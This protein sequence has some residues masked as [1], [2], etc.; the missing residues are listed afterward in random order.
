MNESPISPIETGTDV[1]AAC[2]R[3]LDLREQ[4]AATS[5]APPETERVPTEIDHEIPHRSRVCVYHDNCHDGITAAWV[6][7]HR[8]GADV[9]L[10]PAKYEVPPDLD[11]L[12]GRDVIIVDFSWKRPVLEQVLAVA[13]SLQIIDHHASAQSDLD[14]FPGCTFDM[15]RSGAGL[16]WDTLFPGEL[17]PVLVDLVEDRDLWRFRLKNTKAVHAACNLR[18]LDIENRRLLVEMADAEEGLEALVDVGASVLVYHD[19]LV[20]SGSRYRPRRVIGGHSVPC[21]PGGTV[22]LISD[23]G[24]ALCEGESFAATWAIKSDLT[25]LV[26]LRSSQ[27]GIDVCEIARAYGGGGHKHAAGFH[28][29]SASWFGGQWEKAPSPCWT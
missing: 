25:V 2:D 4:I 9:E 12:S 15:S 26:S 10:Y 19:K 5:E 23:V 21:V 18:P 20:Q 29:D 17:R 16:T 22:E 1:V 3:A 7:Q 14:G 11:R 6:V 24:H 27:E 13:A 28:T 8:Y